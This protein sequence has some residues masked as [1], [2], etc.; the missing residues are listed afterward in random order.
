MKKLNKI[1]SVGLSLVMCAG[2]AAPAFAMDISQEYINGLEK[3]TNRSGQ[4]DYVELNSDEGDTFNFLEDIK[5]DYTLLFKNAGNDVVLDLNGFTVTKKNE[6]SK[7]SVI[8]VKDADLTV[9]G[10]GGVITGGMAYS[11]NGSSTYSNNGG[12]IRIENGNLT[13]N[14]VTLKNNEAKLNGGAIEAFTTDKTDTVTLNNVTVTNN[15]VTG[16]GGGAVR[17]SGYGTVNLDKVQIADNTSGG[18]GGGLGIQNTTKVE[19]CH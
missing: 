6:E 2:M 17:V 14:D 8:L 3:Q 13:V 11:N 5:T 15:E 16:T 4:Y 9:N 10:G 7:G 1:L 18:A 19:Q 12:G